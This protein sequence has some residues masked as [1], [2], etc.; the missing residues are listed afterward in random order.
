MHRWCQSLSNNSALLSPA[1]RIF[2]FLIWSYSIACSNQ[3]SGGVPKNLNAALS[4]DAARSKV[5]R[6][7]NCLHLLSLTCGAL[8][9]PYTSA[10]VRTLTPNDAL[11]NP[12][13]QRHRQKK[14]FG[15]KRRVI[16]AGKRV[17]T[18]ARPRPAALHTVKTTLRDSPGAVYDPLPFAPVRRC[19]KEQREHDHYGLS[20][21]RGS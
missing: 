16:S 2:L 20:T 7:A 11:H 12:K 6:K 1:T 13:H 19:S 9:E 5:D 3:E 17:N 15:E 4:R 14:I 8:D 21:R 10:G 18:L